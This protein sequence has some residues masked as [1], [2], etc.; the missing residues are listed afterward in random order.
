MP[1]I[2]I[3]HLQVKLFVAIPGLGYSVYCLIALIYNTVIQVNLYL[4]TIVDL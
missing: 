1:V 2:K 4:F 3:H